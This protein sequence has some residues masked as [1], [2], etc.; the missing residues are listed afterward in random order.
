MSEE[1]ATYNAGGPIRE[2]CFK[3]FPLWAQPEPE[4]VRTLIQQLGWSNAQ[5]AR[6]VGVNDGKQ[7]RRWKAGQAAIPYG[8]WAILAYHAGHMD[9]CFSDAAVDL[10][11][12]P[13]LGALIDDVDDLDVHG[14][15]T[16]LMQFG[17]RGDKAYATLS[18]DG[19]RD[20]GLEVAETF[21]VDITGKSQIEALRLIE[22]KV[23]SFYE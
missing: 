12:R 11:L 14:G 13:N 17:P 22:E 20:D 3:P 4:E 19:V 5:I 16:T 9:T 15:K 2:E 8:S 10:V 18:H 21:R 7:V 23:M 1:R 6:L